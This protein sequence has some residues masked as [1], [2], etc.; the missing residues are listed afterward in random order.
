MLKAVKTATNILAL[1]L[2]IA[3]LVPLARGQAHGFKYSETSINAKGQPLVGATIT[4]CASPAIGAPCTPLIAIF[5]D[6]ALT[7]P[8]GNPFQSDS[9]GNW[10]F[11]VSPGVYSYTVSGNGTIAQGPIQ[12][13]VPCVIGGAS[14]ASSS[15]G[16][17][18]VDANVIAKGTGIGLPLVNSEGF[19][20]GTLPAQWPLGLNVV[21]QGIWYRWNNAVSP[22]TVANQ[23]AVATSTGTVNHGFTSTVTGVIGIAGNGAGTTGQVDICWA[24][25]C[26]V[27]FDNTSNPEDWAI[28]STTT[29]GYLHDTGSQLETPGIQN[30][31]IVGANAGAGTLGVVALLSPDSIGTANN[32]TGVMT[33]LG[34]TIYGGTSGACTRLPGSTSPNGVPRIWT[35]TAAA[36]VATAPILSLF[37]IAP[38]QVTAATD[39]VLDIDRANGI[40][41]SRTTSIAETVPSAASFGSNFPF[42]TLNK[43]IG[44]VTLTPTTSTVNGHASIISYYGDFSTWS[45]D[46]TNYTARITRAGHTCSIPIGTDNGSVL[47]DADLG[48]QG[49][50][51]QVPPYGAKVIEIDVKADGGTPNV[52]VRKEHGASNTNLL[53]GALA[54]GAAGVVA[55]SNAGGTLSIDGVTTCTNTLQ[56]VDVVAG[57][58]FGLTSGTAGGVAKRMSISIIFGETP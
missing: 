3:V 13:T 49:G 32:C 31:L 48:P 11:Y 34:D 29:A 26:Q 46:N 19:A 28:P 25:R 30:F 36:G 18:N 53:S 57:D 1:T 17:S 9:L 24:G 20:D 22:G 14:C 54:T 8:K 40:E 51:C 43:N 35:S 56:N 42:Y 38:R 23:T 47:V 10:S 52:I 6:E 5:D 12:I 39:T 45:S 16:G 44:P 58:W 15:G 2:L 21:S 33:L 41:F 4:V 27:L 37:G 7:T 55:C 50:L